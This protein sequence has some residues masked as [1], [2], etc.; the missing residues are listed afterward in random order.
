MSR[1]RRK[2]PAP[3]TFAPSKTLPM[4]FQKY[5]DIAT[6]GWQQYSHLLLMSEVI[7]KQYRMVR[8]AEWSTDRHDLPDEIGEPMVTLHDSDGDRR[9]IIQ[10]GSVLVSLYLRSGRIRV[11]VAADTHEDLKR[12]LDWW[13]EK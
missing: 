11:L 12:E 1:T 9:M 6:M 2:G 10:R 8:E 13:H 3:R 4:S 7:S 5:A